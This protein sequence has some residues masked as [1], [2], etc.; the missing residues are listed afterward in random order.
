MPLLHFMG[1]TPLGTSFSIAFCA[2][3]A[4]NEI[5]YSKA[6]A[7]FIR[8]IHGSSNEAKIK[9]ILTDNESQLK[10]ALS[11]QLPEIPQLLCVWH[12]NK[13]VQAEA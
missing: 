7:S 9:V 4:E 12:V 1:V 8:S 13:N 2:M 5:Q 11:R 10:K 6:I 3:A